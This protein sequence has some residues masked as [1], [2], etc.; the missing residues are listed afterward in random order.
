M[1]VVEIMYYLGYRVSRG[2]RTLKKKTLSHPVISVGNITLGGTGKTPAVIALAEEAVRRGFRPCILTRGYRGRLKKP[3]FVSRGSGP[4]YSPF[5]AGDEA[6]LMAQR[7]HG[8][9]VIKAANRHEGA[10]LSR[11]A[12]LFILDDGYQ[13]W[14]LHRDKNILLIDAIDPFGNGKLFPLGPLREPLKEIRRADTI[15]VTRSSGDHGF[16]ERLKPYSRNAAF[17]HASIKATWLI[18]QN[19]DILPAEHLV[20]KRIYAFC[21]IGNPG[22]FIQT[23]LKFGILL[24]GFKSFPDHHVYRETEMEAMYQESVRTMADMIITTEKDFIK[25]GGM[26]LPDS[27]TALRVEFDINKDFY[28]SIFVFG[29]KK[30]I[31]GGGKG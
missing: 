6:V 11:N 17:Y 3:V 8:V 28:D 25:L 31:A 1:N 7:L 15:V 22:G 23:L 30:G 27:V 29:R 18:K 10:L 9:E 26:I 14:G 2:Y 20:G 13:H 19:G 24:V 21:G 12:N 4:L 5:E 16:I